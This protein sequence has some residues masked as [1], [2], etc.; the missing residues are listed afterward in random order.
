MF[1]AKLAKCAKGFLIL[2]IMNLFLC[3]K[4]TLKM[5]IY[6]VFLGIDF[7]LVVSYFIS[8]LFSGMYSPTCPIAMPQDFLNSFTSREVECSKR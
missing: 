5:P 8:A 7:S 3:E 6:I 4:K 1:L 2:F